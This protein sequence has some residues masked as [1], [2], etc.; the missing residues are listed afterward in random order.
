VA[1]AVEL[2]YAPAGVAVR[3]DLRRAHGRLL[4]HLA[5]PG[6]WWTGAERV[7][8][9]AESRNAAAC[10]L[11][12]ERKGALSPAAVQGEH[13]SLGALPAPLVDVIHRV[14]TDPGRLSRS[15]FDGILA[16]G[17]DEGSYVEAIGL[18]AMLAGVDSFARALELPPFPL[19]E[20]LPGTPS[21]HRPASARPGTAWVAMIAPEDAEGPEH[22]LYGTADFV[23]NIVR[24]LS[25]VPDHVRVL[26]ELSSAH[27]MGFAEIPDFRRRG[28]LDRMQME[29]IAAR[30]SSL[31][32]CFY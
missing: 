8:I 12:R 14:R 20:P 17:L 22:D 28:A 23:P 32:E 27:Y 9:A 1:V 24:A 4:R 25:L 15:W 16:S 11:C 5:S 6:S 19:P 7:A 13:E 30:V 26:R 10:G 29:L 3:E 2:D 21:R 18:V 31:N